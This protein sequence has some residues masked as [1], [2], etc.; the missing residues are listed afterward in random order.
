MIS[1]AI[2]AR[3]P[4]IEA[5]HAD[6]FHQAIARRLPGYVGDAEAEPRHHAAVELEGALAERGLRADRADQAAD[7][8]ALFQLRQTLI[9]APGLGEPDRAFVAEGDRQRLHRVGAAR[10]RRVLVRLGEPIELAPDGLQVAHEHRVRLL[11]LQHDAGVE[12]VLRGGAE[13][14]IFAVVAIADRLQGAQ[15][16]YQRMLGAADVS[17]DGFEIDQADLRLAGDL[18]GGGPRNDAELGLR[19]RE[20]GLVVIPCLHAVLVVEDRAQ[21]VGAPHVLEQGR[22]ENAGWHGSLPE[23]AMLR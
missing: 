11:D 13:M 17:G 12:H 7:E 4:P 16:R 15:R 20:R 18:G 10:H 23:L 6:I 1:L 21:L 9:V 8:H 3:L 2:L 14:Q 19:Q 5:E 22:V